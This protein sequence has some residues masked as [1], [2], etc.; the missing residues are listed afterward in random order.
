MKAK[1][2]SE[3]VLNDHMLNIAGRITLDSS[4]VKWVRDFIEELADK[5]LKNWQSIQ[6]TKDDRKRQLSIRRKRVK[7]AFLD[8]TFTKEEFREEITGIDSEITSLD[9][10]VS[11]K[12]DW[13]FFLLSLINIG[14]EI[15]MIWKSGGVTDKRAVLTKLGLKFVWDEE[16]LS[17]YAPIWL[18]TFLKG[19]Y[20]IKEKNELTKLKNPLKKKGDLSISREISPALCRMW[21]YNQTEFSQKNEANDSG[22]VKLILE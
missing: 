12:D 14:S 9:K 18:E 16:I 5:E 19:L 7:D 2:I 4:L 15:Q 22:L 8:G 13:K 6:K 10:T 20:A 21:V 1:G 11:K 17:I 3:D